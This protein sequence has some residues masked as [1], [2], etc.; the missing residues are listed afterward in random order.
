[1]ESCIKANVCLFKW[2]VNDKVEKTELKITKRLW[3]VDKPVAAVTYHYL[4]GKDTEQF[5]EKKQEIVKDEND[6]S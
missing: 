5:G 6:K 2:L 4:G 1:M 3:C